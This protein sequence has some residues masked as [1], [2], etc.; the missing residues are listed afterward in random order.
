MAVRSF[1]HGGLKRLCE[2]E[3]ER[4]IHPS[5]R[6]RVRAVL[7]LVD[8]AESPAGLAAPGYRLHLLKGRP[9]CGSM[10]VSRNWRIVIRVED[11]EAWDVDLVAYPQGGTSAMAMRNP[12]H[13]GVNVREGWMVDGMSVSEAAAWGGVPPNTL[14]RVL[15][16]R[17][18]MSPELASRLG[19][20]SLVPQGPVVAPA[21][22]L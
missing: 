21:G 15:D 1:K 18:G 17:E 8:Q 7:A 19:S 12:P 3:D 11:S 9:N 22:R 2:R 4:R 16:G 10:R 14:G 20:R 13:P 5:F 6:K